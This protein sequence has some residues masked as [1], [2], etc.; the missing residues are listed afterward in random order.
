MIRVV[1][2]I[3]QFYAG[4]GGEEKADITPESR[5][6]F[7]GPGMGLNGL[8]KGE[9]TIVGTI[10]CGDSYFNENME[11]AEAKIIEM[12]KEFKPDLFI[13][14]PAFNA[15]RYGVA[16]GAVAKAVEEKLNI[17]V[18]TAM[19]P[20]NPGADMYKKHVYI[21]ETRNSAVGM[22]QALPAVAKLALKLAK[23]EEILLPSEDGYIERGIRKN[24]FNAKRG[25]ERAVDLLVKKL[26]GEEFESEFK[27]P[28]FDRVEALPPVADITKAKIAI[29]TSG[30]TVPKGNPDHIES[31]SASKYG[32]YNIEG[33]M[34]LTKDTYET[35]HGGYDPT[36]AN[37]DSDRVIPVDVL[38]N[39]E[40]EGKIGSLHNLFYSTVGNGTAV[41]S[42]KKFGEEI[43]KKLIA[44]G[45]D[46][47][48]LT[49]T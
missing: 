8:L 6:G 4:I 5:E 19:Y 22:R 43:A 25:S 42:S 30:G 49:S 38:R 31:S 36:Y 13:A 46:A 27:M 29:V 14:G 17:P 2:Y 33:V 47:V 7:I 21:V 39:M 26:K 18:L 44:D 1:H 15:G 48:I 10:I 28:V 3:N 35:A 40:K 11:E 37:D 20:E 24:Y 23:G 34:D 16:C 32:E 41:A 45:V 9:A 12:V